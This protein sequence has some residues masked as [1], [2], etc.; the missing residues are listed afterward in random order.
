MRDEGISSDHKTKTTSTKEK[1]T[2][3]ASYMCEF[4]INDAFIVRIFPL[5]Y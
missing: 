2:L 1:I 3:T 5:C 4:K